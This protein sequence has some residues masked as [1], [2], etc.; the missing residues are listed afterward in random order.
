MS[1][2]HDEFMERVVERVARD[3]AAESRGCPHYPGLLKPVK[4][5]KK[6]LLKCSRCGASVQPIIF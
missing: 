5:G 4:E 6:L 3:L 1:L 2:K